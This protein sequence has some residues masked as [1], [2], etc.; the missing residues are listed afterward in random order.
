MDK[1]LYVDYEGIEIDLNDLTIYPDCW[2]EKESYDLWFMAVK[3]AGESLFF[4]DYL[5]PDIDWGGQR[6]RVDKLCKELAGI[7][8]SMIEDSLKNRLKIMKFLYRLEDE[9]ENQC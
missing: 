2:K 1:D 7:R 8:V 3:R 6:I 5:H 9:V 4:M